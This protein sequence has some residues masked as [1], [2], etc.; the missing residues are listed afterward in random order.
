[1]QSVLDIWQ[2]EGATASW[3]EGFVA[4]LSSGSRVKAEQAIWRR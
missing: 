4:R 1:M 2:L 3:L